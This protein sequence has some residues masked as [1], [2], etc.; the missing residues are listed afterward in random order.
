M[1]EKIKIIVDDKNHTHVWIDGVKIKYITKIKFE[2]SEDN[3]HIPNIEIKKRF[4]TNTKSRFCKTK[5]PNGRYR[6]I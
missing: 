3:S 5:N 2:V 6:Y 4:S 1:K